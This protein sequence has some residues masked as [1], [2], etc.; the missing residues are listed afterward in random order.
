MRVPPPPPPLL[1]TLGNVSKGDFERRTS[2]GSGLFTFL[3]VGFAQIFSQFSRRK[4]HLFNFPDRIK[5]HLMLT[6]TNTEHTLLE[7]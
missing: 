7:I 6:S 1:P 2:T 4:A 5:R 3:S